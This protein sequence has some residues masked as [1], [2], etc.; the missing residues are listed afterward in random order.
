MLDDCLAVVSSLTDRLAVMRGKIEGVPPAQRWEL[1]HSLLS[2]KVEGARWIVCDAE[3]AFTLDT[4]TD[5]EL[6]PL[7]A[8]VP[9]LVGC[10]PYLGRALADEA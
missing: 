9:F 4:L 1:E 10:R 6:V 7:T 2:S 5:E 8:G 3:G